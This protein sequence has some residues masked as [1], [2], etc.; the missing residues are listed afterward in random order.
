[1]HA[2]YTRS[3]LHDDMRF[4]CKKRY[5]YFHIIIGNA[6]L[7]DTVHDAVRYDTISTFRVRCDVI[8]G[9]RGEVYHAINETV[10]VLIFIVRFHANI[11]TTFTLRLLYICDTSCLKRVFSI[12]GQFRSRSTCASACNDQITLVSTDGKCRVNIAGLTDKRTV[13]LSSGDSFSTESPISRD[14]SYI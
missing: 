10:N 1:M 5:H 14:A 4:D 7:D 12:C 3:M 9:S 6:L 2:H 13:K 8:G 11:S